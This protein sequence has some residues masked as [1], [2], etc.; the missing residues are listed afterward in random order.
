MSEG[1]FFLFVP[2]QGGK[3]TNSVDFFLNPNF[4]GMKKCQKIICLLF[5]FQKETSPGA[6]NRHNEQAQ[7]TK[8]LPREFLEESR[9]HSTSHRVP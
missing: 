6:N 3:K 9:G 1:F 4:W 8:P 5:F 7:P 2:E